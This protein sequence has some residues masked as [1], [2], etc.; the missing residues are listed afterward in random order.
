MFRGVY[1]KCYSG[2]RKIIWYTGNIIHFIIILIGFF[3]SA[4]G[5]SQISYWAEVVITNLIGSIPVIG[6][7]LKTTLLGVNIVG[8][9]TL[10]KFFIFHCILPFV[11]LL[12]IIWHSI[13]VHARGQTST[14]EGRMPISKSLS[15][16]IQSL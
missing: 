8:D 15:I 6:K 3:G 12:F 13:L 2:S 1:Y 7:Y 14:I 10:R 5:W 4:L 9:S 11:C 16:F